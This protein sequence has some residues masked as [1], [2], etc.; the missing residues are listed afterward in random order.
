M[1][2]FHIKWAVKE[3]I[4]GPGSHDDGVRDGDVRAAEGVVDKESESAD[5]LRSELT[6]VLKANFP[7]HGLGPTYDI[8][9]TYEIDITET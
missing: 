3:H 7:P 4:N 6:E 1:A 5:A 9:R 2:L 8:D